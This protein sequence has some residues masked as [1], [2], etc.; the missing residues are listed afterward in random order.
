MQLHNIPDEEPA[1][2]YIS[3]L[4]TTVIG[5]KSKALH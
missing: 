4:N 5:Y 1:N 2:V 3:L